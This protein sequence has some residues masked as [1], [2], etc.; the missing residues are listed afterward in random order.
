MGSAAF[1]FSKPSILL[2]FMLSVT[3][4]TA[5]RG[6][7]KF[8]TDSGY[9]AD[10]MGQGMG[11][12][13]GL[14]ANLDN[15][16]PLLQRTEGDAL[17]AVLARLFFV[18]WPVDVE[19][20]RRVIP[21]RT[22]SDCVETGLLSVAG[23]NFESHGALLP[24]PNLICASDASR[25]R[26]MSPDLVIGPSATTHLIARLAVPGVAEST[27]DIG[28]GS[29]V[30]ALHAAAYSKQ[31]TGTDI[32]ER[33]LVFAKYN[34]ALN[35]IS[36]VEFVCGDAF[37]PVQGRRFSRVIANPPFFLS[38][39]KKFTYS[40]SP[41]E[42]DGFSRKLAKE[43]PQYLEDGG[44]FQMICEWVQ[45]EGERWEQRLN[46]WFQG[47]GCDVLIL[48][49]PR[50]S[51]IDYAEKRFKEA[52]VLLPYRPESFFDERIDYFKKQKVE[53]ILGGV[54]TMRKRSGSNWFS[55]LTA[56]PVSTRG[57]EAVRERFDTITF[58]GS[59]S[60]ENLMECRFRLADDVVM[61]Q[62]SGFGAAGWQTT[63]RELAKTAG[64]QDR[65]RLDAAVAQFIEL[66]DG[67]HA[68][69]E[70]A[71]RV[72]QTLQLPPE[73]AAQR[74]MQLARRLLQ[75]SFVHPV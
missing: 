23:N 4:P 55:L 60:N 49:G 44:F 62:R 66:F 24:F 40:D 5:V 16:Q 67:R 69:C 41:L 29:G 57:G 36:Q 32:N 70:I 6:I 27:L 42:L 58:A 54:I 18:A 52:Q 28:T 34:A 61:E 56:D 73:E 43:A 2:S 72:S 38:P 63:S 11:L 37:I 59:H 17:L 50:L 22:L 3:S 7:G 31:V 20:C 64:F 75:S 39:A 53:T 51:P 45:I 9:D 15:L 26:G 47:A 10:H 48:Q 30:L 12:S 1:L 35:G 33:S 71:Q 46:E 68:L 65:L 13:E 8:L 25:L 74:C 19:L 21:E 14:Y